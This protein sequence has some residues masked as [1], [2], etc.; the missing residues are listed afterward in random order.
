METPDVYI[1]PDHTNVTWTEAI[2]LKIAK[3]VDPC[4]LSLTKDDFI[5]LNED[6][7]YYNT[8]IQAEKKQL[9]RRIYERTCIW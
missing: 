3:E 6:E 2:E 8:L 1:C 5:S 7:E 9:D 4:L